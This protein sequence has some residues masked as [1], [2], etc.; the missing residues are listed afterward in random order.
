M[1]LLLKRLYLNHF[2]RFSYST[3]DER[4]VV[5]ASELE[6]ISTIRLDDRKDIQFVKS[7]WSILH[8]ELKARALPPLEGNNKGRKGSYTYN[9][10][11][12]G[13]LEW[14][15]QNEMLSD[16]GIRG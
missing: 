2:C 12:E 16:V 1:W 7:A 11:F 6:L 3:A 5:N 8:S 13:R 10:H 14:K 15:G 9:V 4:L